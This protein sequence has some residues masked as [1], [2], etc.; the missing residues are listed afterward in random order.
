MQYLHKAVATFRHRRQHLQTKAAITH[1][2]S[3]IYTTTVAT[4]QHLYSED[5]IYKQ[6]QLHLHSDSNMSSGSGSIHS[7]SKIYA[8]IAK[9]TQSKQYL[10]IAA[11][12]IIYIHGSNIHTYVVAAMFI[13]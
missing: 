11:S 4:C 8:Y 13:Q 10:H 9:I 6:R 12:S 3:N 2:D 1:C 7:Y 5:N